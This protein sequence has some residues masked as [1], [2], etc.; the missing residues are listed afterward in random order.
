MIGFTFLF[1]Q[2][3][4]SYSFLFSIKASFLSI[5]GN[6][7]EENDPF[8]FSVWFIIGFIDIMITLI[9]SNFLIAIISS[10]YGN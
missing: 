4:N 5:F 6:L 1:T 7:L 10:K 8:D 3:K 9:L 2:S